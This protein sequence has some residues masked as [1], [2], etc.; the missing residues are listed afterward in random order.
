[1]KLNRLSKIALFCIV[2]SVATSCNPKPTAEESEKLIRAAD[3]ELSGL[4]NR[5]MGTH[6]I[7]AFLEVYRLT[8]GSL[9]SMPGNKTQHMTKDLRVNIDTLTEGQ[10]QITFPYHFKSDTVAVFTLLSKKNQSSLLMDD[11]PVDFRCNISTPSGVGLLE[12][13]YSAKLK[14]GLPENYEFVAHTGGFEILSELKTS[15]RKKNS[16]MRVLFSVTENMKS[17][18]KFSMISTVDLDAN[19]S[20]RFGR[21]KMLLEVFPIVVELRGM[22]GFHTYNTQQ[23]VSD[24]NADNHIAIFDQQMNLIGKIQLTKKDGKDYF[25]PVVR[26]SDSKEYEIEELMRSI[27]QLLRMKLHNV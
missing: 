6:G 12:I 17:K 18:V 13:N 2:V 3:A 27:K 10:V 23:F 4:A 14:N 20:I 16:T 24:F 1:M 5:M 15:F 11:F 26:L 25:N 21:K 22:R 8:G 9:A 7:K 19:Q